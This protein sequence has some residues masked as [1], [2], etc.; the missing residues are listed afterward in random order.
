MT[1]DNDITVSCRSIRYLFGIGDL[2]KIAGIPSEMTELA[3]SEWRE[4]YRGGGTFNSFYVRGRH[5]IHITSSGGDSWCGFRT[6]LSS[7]K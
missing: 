1:E 5:N 4:R 3:Y 2:G 6:T 7:G